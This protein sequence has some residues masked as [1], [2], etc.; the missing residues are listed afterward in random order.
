MKTGKQE[1][2]LNPQEDEREH[3]DRVEE[4]PPEAATADSSADGNDADQADDGDGDDKAAAPKKPIW[5]RP[6]FLI[7]VAVVI[8][9]LIAGGIYYW[10]NV[11]PYE[12]TDDAFIDANTIQISPQTSGQIVAVGVGNNTH[13]NRGQLLVSIDPAPAKANLASAKAQ[14][15]QAR[16]E[17]QQA[18]ASAEQAR[19]QEAQ[20]QAQ[21]DALKV[22][23]E[24]ANENFKRN[25]SLFKDNSGSISEKVVDDSEAAYKQAQAQAEAGRQE[26]ATAKA[27]IG[28]A[29]AKVTAA[30]AAVQAAQ[31]SVDTAQIDVDHTTITA[32][33]SGQIVQNSLG[34]GAF[35]SQGNPLMVLVPD[36]IF[37]T[38][39]YKET[40]LAD[41]R[42]GQAVDVAV[43]A[44]PDV[45]FKGKVISV[46]QG[47]GQAFQLLPAENATG[48]FVKV[49]QRVPVRISIENPDPK[50]Y[51]LGP[52]MSVVSSIRVD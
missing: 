9:A 7:F 12:T 34:V 43:D 24:N 41:I 16:A 20:S 1:R 33:Q 17:L 38:A 37:V 4:T 52:G 29:D 47:A 25:Q 26:V 22:E 39:N 18:K 27:S 45:D 13:V 11:A 2:P 23:A 6:V 3:E 28:V 30:E 31:A 49:V 50:R 40:Q 48:N 14:L 51:L 8:L 35:A 5:K 21:L 36:D 44:Y 15:A 19:Q 10:I 32:Q 42:V 46:Q